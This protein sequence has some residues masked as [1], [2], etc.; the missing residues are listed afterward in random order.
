MIFT[1]LKKKNYQGPV[2]HS[3]QNISNELKNT[4][5]LIVGLAG[6]LKTGRYEKQ[7]YK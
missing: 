6:K 1:K 4:C 7:L 5:R 2:S 3:F